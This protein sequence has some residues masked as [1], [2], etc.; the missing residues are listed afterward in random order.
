MTKKPQVTLTHTQYIAFRIIVGLLFLQFG[1][2]KLGV[3]GEEGARELLSFMWVIGVLETLVGIG[4]TIG[5]LANISAILGTCIMIGAYVTRHAQ[6]GI[7]P[8]QNNG[9]LA[10]LFLTCFLLILLFEYPT[11]KKILQRIRTVIK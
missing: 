2:S 9:T 5:F 3:F 1:L 10:L 4:L 7:L 6:L 8:A 11:L